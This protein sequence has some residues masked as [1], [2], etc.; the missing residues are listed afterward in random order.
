MNEG[1]SFCDHLIGP[2]PFL[3]AVVMKRGTDL[4]HELLFRHAADQKLKQR[5]TAVQN[6][7][8]ADDEI[9]ERISRCHCEEGQKHTD[10]LRAGVTHEHRTWMAVIPQVHDQ[11][12]TE[13][14]HDVIHHGNALRHDRHD[15]VGNG[16]DH[17]EVSAETVN[18]VRCIRKV[19]GSPYEAG[20]QEDIKRLRDGETEVEDEDIDGPREDEGRK[21]TGS[22]RDHDIGKT[23]F[24]RGPGILIIEVT[25]DH[26][27]HRTKIE[28]CVFP[29]DLGKKSHAHKKTGDEDDAGR[30]RL[31]LRGGSIYGKSS[32]PVGRK[33][34]ILKPD[35]YKSKDQGHDRPDQIDVSI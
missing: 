32:A 16:G 14:E 6:H 4:A 31:S 7:R 18:A 26:G 30:G 19:D 24:R 23:L 1:E 20:R 9:R 10:R 22:Q 11:D 5:R 8:Q 13:V 21:G 28:K 12:D 25:A 27:Q 34:F 15:K 2:G 29:G 33:L 17:G 35:R 3:T